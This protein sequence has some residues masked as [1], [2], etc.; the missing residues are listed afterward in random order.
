MKKAA[1]G[2][3]GLVLVGLVLLVNW[4]ETA[5]TDALLN[6]LYLTG[7]GVIVIGLLIAK[8]IVNK[9]KRTLFVAYH[10]RHEGGEGWTL[11]TVTLNQLGEIVDYQEEEPGYIYLDE[12]QLA[13]RRPDSISLSEAIQAIKGGN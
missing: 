5:S 7:F 3:V 13:L 11:Y 8:S 12:A 1:Q 4:V 6:V 2:F 10:V 9:K